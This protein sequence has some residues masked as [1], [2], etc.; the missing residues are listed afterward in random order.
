M[1]KVRPFQPIEAEYDAAV[2]VNNTNWP[3]NPKTTD[4]EKRSDAH[5]NPAYFFQRLVGEH[6]GRIV[7]TG[8]C[9]ETFW[10]A[11]PDQ[12][13]WHFNILPDYANQGFEEQMYD[14]LMAQ[15]AQRHPRKFFVGMRDDKVE[16]VQF[17]ETHGY[18]LIQ[19]EPTSY[20]DVR[21]FDV[22][23]FSDVM[24]RVQQQGI[25]ILGVNRLQQVDPEWMQKLWNLQWEIKQDVPGTGQARE[26]FEEFKKRVND[27]NHYDP[28]AHFAAVHQ[29]DADGNDAGSYVGMTRLTY[30]KVDPTL[31]STHL[32]GVV[33]SYRRRG[34]ATALKVHAIRIAKAQG[35]RRIDTMNHEDNPMLALN[36]H[37]GFKPGPAWLYYEKIL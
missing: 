3:D 29:T 21:T 26:M 2:A 35:V 10:L 32:T 8:E 13:S 14:S 12:Y 5:R 37:L 36:I 19:R 33:R 22:S 18:R 6:S 30:N 34:V 1:L 9:G 7:A 31:G 16:Q 11:E 24:T 27:A 25:Q 15:L 17:I 20:L 28:G 23:H 4:E